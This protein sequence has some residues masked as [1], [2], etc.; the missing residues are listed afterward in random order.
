MGTESQQ[1]GSLVLAGGGPAYGFAVQSHD[2][3]VAGGASSLD[4]GRQHQLD[5]TDTQA[6]QQT[7]IERARGGVEVAWPKEP[8]QQKH[9]MVTPLSHGFQRVAVTRALP[10]PG[11]SASRASHSVVHGGNADQVRWQTLHIN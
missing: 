2:F 8:T 9:L 4:P 5:V 10:L 1:M 3:L 11:R 7:T 6:G